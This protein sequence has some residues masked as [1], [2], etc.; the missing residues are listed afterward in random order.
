MVSAVHFAFKVTN[1]DA[2]YEALIAG[3]K[4]ALEMKVQHLRARSDSMLVVYQISGGWQAMGP[5]TELYSKYVR[6][7]IRKFVEVKMEKIPRNENMEANALAKFSSQRDAQML[8]AIPLKIQERASI[9]EVE[10]MQIEEEGVTTW[11]TPI[12]DYIKEGKLP[13]DK[14]EARKLKYKAARY[15]EYDENLYRR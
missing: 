3:M 4:L 1:N 8:G 7:M 5:K 15:V 13:E 12:W 14:S 10:V 9:F 6:E 2:E 11:M